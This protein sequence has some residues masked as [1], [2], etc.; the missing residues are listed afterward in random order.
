[1][2][3]THDLYRLDAQGQGDVST[4]RRT[5]FSCWKATGLRTIF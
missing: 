5:S 3:D 2:K 1:M 4:G